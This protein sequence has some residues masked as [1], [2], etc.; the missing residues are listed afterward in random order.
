MSGSGISW[1]ICNSAPRSRQI[2][3]PAPPPLRRM[4]FLPPNQQ[5]QST[6]GINKLTYLL[7]YLLII[8]PNQILVFISFIS[9]SVDFSSW[10]YHFT[11][12]VKRHKTAAPILTVHCQLIRTSDAISTLAFYP[13][14]IL[15][16]K[17]VRSKS[18]RTQTFFALNIR[19][20]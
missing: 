12:A 11:A 2:T 16:V 8:P 15:C 4:P 9:R 17:T 1:A 7:T 5:R 14:E 10:F 6:E 19:I 18:C 20:L 3:T 13:I